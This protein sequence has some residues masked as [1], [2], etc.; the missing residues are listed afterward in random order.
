MFLSACIIAGYVVCI[1]LIQS[2]VAV[3]FMRQ[4]WRFQRRR[5]CDESL[6]RAAIVMS[7]RGTD[8][9][10]AETIERLLYQD[11][12]HYVI[13]I[14][15]DGEKDPAVEVIRGVIQRRGATNVSISFLRGRKT[16]C[17][18][19]CQALAQAIGELDDDCE[20]VA[21]I[22][23]DALPYPAWLRDLVRPLSDT[24]V[25]VTTGNRWYAPATAHWG[26]LVRY[27]WNAG[28]IVQ[29][30][31]NGIVWAGSMAM[32][33][34]VIREIG[35][36][37][38]WG[39]ALSVDATVGRLLHK[40]GYGVSFVPGVM[41]VNTESI[42]LG[43]FMS[44]VQRQLVAAKS[45]GGGWIMVGLH[46]FALT[47][48]QLVSF[49]LLVGGLVTGD[50]V[51]AGISGAA[52]ALFW[53]SSLVTTVTI[54]WLVRRVVRSYD[55]ESR[56]LDGTKVAML[57]LALILT[58]LVFPCLFVGASFRRKVAWRG[59]QYEILGGRAVRMIA[60]RPIG[61]VADMDANASVI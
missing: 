52:L 18:L 11:Y 31:M 32:R 34:E 57:P 15:A 33:T 2:G 55:G 45:S 7:V 27:F 17:S 1:V 54:E 53:G 19:K 22:D 20:V 35:L 13:H 47:A 36:V 44:W 10:L 8:P 3:A 37:D 12:P 39:R 24:R 14:I 16:T 6:P 26:S 59:I 61:A 48:I 46:T 28:A 21:F 29:V 9:Q 40:H 38:G 30:W 5:G 41:L 60:Y 49:S 43:R 56:W 58:Y 42:T 23:G 50:H 51:V 4:L 25:G